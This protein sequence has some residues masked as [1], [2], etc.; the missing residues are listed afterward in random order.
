MLD[1][2]VEELE[3]KVKKLKSEVDREAKNK[4][5]SEVCNAILEVDK[6]VIESTKNARY[7]ENFAKE[8]S[9]EIISA[10]FA[11]R[12]NKN[13]AA[14]TNNINR[15]CSPVQVATT[16]GD[17]MIDG[18]KLMIE[19]IKEATNIN[20]EEIVSKSRFPQK[21]SKSIDQAL[22]NYNS[23]IEAIE[24]ALKLIPVAVNDYDNKYFPAFKEWS[25][26]EVILGTKQGKSRVQF[27][28]QQLLN[29]EVVNPRLKKQSVSFKGK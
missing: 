12:K 4:S 8:S 23:T 13:I 5:F 19:R 27:S 28:Q 17:I 10:E 25:K 18:Y 2:S 29:Y 22:N 3:N 20:K 11:M 14:A 26:A 16:F 15:G 7:L 9:Q 6:L 21:M 1:L 24:R